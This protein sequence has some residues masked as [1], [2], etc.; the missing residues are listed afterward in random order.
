MRLSTCSSANW[1]PDPR[2]LISNGTPALP[3]IASAPKFTL[4]SHAT[5]ADGDIEH[6]LLTSIVDQSGKPLLKAG[7]V[8]DDKF[9]HGI[10]FY[11]KGVQGQLP[12]AK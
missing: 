5:K 6:S 2:A 9:L 12:A 8:G 1:K 4:T 11:V 10:N 7:E 3:K